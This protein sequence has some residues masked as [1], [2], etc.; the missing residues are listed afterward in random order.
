M[1]ESNLFGQLKYTTELWAAA[2]FLALDF[3][4]IRRSCCLWLN[5][6]TQRLHR[7]R[8]QGLES[9]ANRTLFAKD[10]RR[11]A[12][13]PFSKEHLRRQ[14]SWLRYCDTIVQRLASSRQLVLNEWLIWEYRLLCSKALLNEMRESMTAL[15]DL[16]HHPKRDN[17]HICWNDA[18]N[19]ISKNRRLRPISWC[20]DLFCTEMIAILCEL[21]A[22]TRAHNVYIIAA[23]FRMPWLSTT[24]A[25]HQNT[26]V[27]NNLNTFNKI[28]R[29]SSCLVKAE[30]A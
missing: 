1:H 6:T 27:L 12:S 30:A 28:P 19:I 9:R 23:K 17:G 2:N 13:S 25:L 5:G 11:W 21:E 29:V 14:R 10:C 15:Q 16:R 22:L 18:M 24:D 7:A 26:F 20:Q 3:F 4:S 8:R